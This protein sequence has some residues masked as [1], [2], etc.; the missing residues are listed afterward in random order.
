MKALSILGML[1][2]LVIIVAGYIV[3]ET[4]VYVSGSA[5]GGSG[6]YSTPNDLDG[7]GYFIITAGIFFL[8]L[9]SIGIKYLRRN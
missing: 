4:R 8:V 5:Y 6:Y 9:S 3:S 1:L 2:S 7:W